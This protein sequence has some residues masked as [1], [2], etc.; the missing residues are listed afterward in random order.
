MAFCD[1]TKLFSAVGQRIVEICEG[2]PQYKIK[3]F[4]LFEI[5][6]PEQKAY[7]ACDKVLRASL[8]VSPK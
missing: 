3:S 1:D 8:A 4:I 6:T 2:L 7:S 5:I